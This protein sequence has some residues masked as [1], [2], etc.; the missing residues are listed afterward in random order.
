MGNETEF[1]T[2]NG[3]KLEMRRETSFLTE[4]KK[5]RGKTG[6]TWRKTGTK[7]EKTENYK[8]YKNNIFNFKNGNEILTRFWKML[9]TEIRTRII[10]E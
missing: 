7:Q 8:K 9:K 2:R 1:K 5:N 6:K 3:R 10:R 4:K